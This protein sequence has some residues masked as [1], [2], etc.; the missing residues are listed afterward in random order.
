LTDTLFK[1]LGLD[2]NILRAI[3][4]A[5]YKHPTEIQEKAIPAILMMKD[6]IGI[7][8]T[9]TGK[10]AS[11]TLPMI[12]IL[13][14]G[15]AKARMP[16]ALVLAPTRELAAQVAENIEKYAKYISLSHAL[17]VG[18]V[19]ASDQIAKLERG[20]DILI[21]TPGR[22]LDLFE[23][24]NVLLNDI[25][26][27]VI[28]EA[29]RMLD[30]G[31]IPDIE[32]ITKIVPPLKQSLLFSATFAKPIQK[33]AEQLMDNPKRIEVAKQ[34]SAALTV[35]QKLIVLKSSRD[36]TKALVD[37]IKSE[38]VDTAFVFC[39]RKKDID[40]YAAA[41]VKSGVKAGS[42][43][44]DMAQSSR[45][46]TLNDFKSG[47][48]KVLVCS[49]VAG[50][51]IDISDVGHVFNMDLPMNA[52]DYVHRIGRTGRAGKS[53]AAFSFAVLPHDDKFLEAIEKLIGNAIER[54][55]TF[56]NT[57]KKE[58][59][60]A[61]KQSDNKAAAKEQQTAKQHTPKKPNPNQKP[62][63]YNNEDDIPSPEGFGDE[64]PDFMRIA[65]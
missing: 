63:H 46:Q 18:G 44:G 53:G 45:T 64:V 23:R 7:A 33:L 26:F 12:E 24:G 35:T 57:P 50:R 1:D 20:V 65:R 47:V 61:K 11:F 19:Q 22:L 39:N 21:A 4:D 62:K 25:K 43:H 29:D 10:T 14:G 34:A 9:G 49:D 40:G 8:Q 27:L 38:N 55:A 6:V 13:H 3:D 59:A 17:I 41:L 52:E 15:I 60:P 30:M 42:L 31:F 48:I 5:G 36:K 16:R 28:D 58:S 56:K 37:K 2:A 54:E 51:G 32:R